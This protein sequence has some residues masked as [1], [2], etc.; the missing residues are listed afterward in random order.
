VVFEQLVSSRY[1]CW[2]GSQT[3]MSYFFAALP[4]R[5]PAAIRPSIRS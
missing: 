3:S 4:P 2:P 1:F 5:S